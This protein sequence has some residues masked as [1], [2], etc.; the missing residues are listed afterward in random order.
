MATFAQ[1]TPQVTPAIANNFIPEIWSDEVIATYETN[2]VLAPLVKKLSMKGKKGDVIHIPKPVRGT[3]AAKVA[4]TAVTVQA[5][6]NTK[7]D[8]TIDQHWEYSRMIEDIADVQSLSSMRQFYTSDAGYAMAKQVDSDLFSLGTGLGD[9]TALSDSAVPAN[10]EHT[11]TI[12]NTA[13]GVKEAWAEDTMTTAMVF[14]DSL[15]RHAMQ[16]LDD[17]D[18]PMMG[19]AFVI[20]PSLCNTIRGLTDYHNMDFAVNKGIENGKIGRL[21]GVD[22]YISTNVPTIETDALNGLGGGTDAVSRGALLIQKDAYV[23]AEQVGVR[24]Q[25]QYKQEF[26]STLYTADRLYGKQVYRPENAVTI[27]VPEAP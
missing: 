24:S 17:N 4:E 26:L 23:L 27:A 15:L 22:V 6:V 8:V 13:A 25:T 11:N 2:L 20:P 21:Y 3:A 9:G 10:W 14:T 7:L 12:R 5:P 1:V 18:V 19:R 16:M